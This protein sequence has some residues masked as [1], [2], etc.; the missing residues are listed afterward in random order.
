MAVHISTAQ[1]LSGSRSTS[2][3]LWV[4]QLGLGKH[5]TAQKSSGCA[6]LRKPPDLCLIKMNRAFASPNPTGLIMQQM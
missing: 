3:L 5:Y 2:N 6:L 4:M 1:G